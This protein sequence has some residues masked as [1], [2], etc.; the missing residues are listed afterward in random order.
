MRVLDYSQ[1]SHLDIEAWITTSESG[2]LVE[3][4][5]SNIVK[6]I[7][8]SSG[9]QEYTTQIEGRGTVDDDNGI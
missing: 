3:E 5:K 9:V 4:P 6:R 2:R 1:D 7:L 8:P